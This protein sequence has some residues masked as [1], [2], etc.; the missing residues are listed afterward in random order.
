MFSACFLGAARPRATLC[1]MARS[2]NGNGDVAEHTLRLL[3]EIR[4]KMATKEDLANL[5]AK[6]ATKED[7]AKVE[8][9]LNDRIDVLTNAV[10]ENHRVFSRRLRVLE[11]RV[12]GR[13]R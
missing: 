4:A 5:E 6:M 12:G 9:R 3:R 8:K 13:P 10:K 1:A 7:L 2:G 11:V